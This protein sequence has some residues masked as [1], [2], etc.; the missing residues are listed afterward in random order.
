MTR[1]AQQQR[2]LDLALAAHRLADERA[3]EIATALWRACDSARHLPPHQVV[4]NRVAFMEARD[5]LDQA[6]AAAFPEGDRH[7]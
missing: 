5:F 7:E 3:E 4:R 1:L 2:I 6:L